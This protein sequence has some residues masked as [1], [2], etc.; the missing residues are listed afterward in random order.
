MNLPFS[1]YAAI[2]GGLVVWTYEHGR[3]WPLLTWAGLSVAVV[4]FWFA[5]GWWLH[6]PR[7]HP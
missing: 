1:T 7:R 2:S 6:A 3:I 5:W 4:A